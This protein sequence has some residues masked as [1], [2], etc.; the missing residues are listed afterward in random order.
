MIGAIVTILLLGALLGLVF[1]KRGQESEGAIQEGKKS[2]WLLGWNCHF[3]HY[4]DYCHYCFLCIEEVGNHLSRII[5]R[6]LLA[7][8][9]SRR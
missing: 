5:H 7:C 9:I 3:C 1:S 8:I 6:Y 2:W 4:R